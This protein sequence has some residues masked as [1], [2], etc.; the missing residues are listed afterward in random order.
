MKTISS[1]T[2]SAAALALLACGHDEPQYSEAPVEIHASFPNAGAKAQMQSFGVQTDLDKMV[3]QGPE[4]ATPEPEY[5]AQGPEYAAQGPDEEVS[6]ARAR[7]EAQGPA[8]DGDPAWVELAPE[9]LQACPNVN[10]NTAFFDADSAQLEQQY[11]EQLEQLARCLRDESLRDRKLEIVGHADPRESRDDSRQL[12]RERA[13]SVAD[14]LTREG[15][16]ADRIELS[17]EGERDPSA[18]ARPTSFERR[19]AIRF[20]D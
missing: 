14:F 12:G 4:V 17:T 19:A 6:G 15:V 7:I 8:E 18:N 3:A 1:I 13:Q 5:A 11:R 20:S 9:I 10:G 2:A 16:Q